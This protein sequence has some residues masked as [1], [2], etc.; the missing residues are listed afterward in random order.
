MSR[1]EAYAPLLWA[2]MDADDGWDTTDEEEA[3]D[4]A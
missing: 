2:E 4:A 1:E 3:R